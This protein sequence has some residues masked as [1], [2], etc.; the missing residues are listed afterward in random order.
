MIT[1][2][3]AVLPESFEDFE[4][5]AARVKTSVS[6]MQID[7]ADGSYAPSRTWPYTSS[8]HFAELVAQDEGL[9]YWEDLEYE[10]DLL[11]RKPEVA[12][13]DWIKA[14]VSGA[15]VHIEST[16]DHG[17]IV[18]M[19]QNAGIDLG[20][21]IKPSTPNEKLFEIID[22]LGMPGFVQ[23]M[24][25]DSIGHGGEDLDESVYDKIAEI[26]ER[27]PDL[28]IAIDIGVNDETAP[29]LVDAGATKLVSGSFIFESPDIPDAIDQLKNL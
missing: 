21:G 1:V 25:S 7:V 28:T 16:D 10:V 9:P 15:V 11:I 22:T 3:P 17:A 8:E 29:D 18:D 24:G 20:W 4:S 2:V 26:R 12:L 6:R 13:A 14:G 19:S 27:Y 23:V 5:H